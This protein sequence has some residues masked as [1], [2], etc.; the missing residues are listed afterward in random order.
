MK[1]HFLKYKYQ[2]IDL[3]SIK[4]IV[5]LKFF[6]VGVPVHLNLRVYCRSSLVLNLFEENFAHIYWWLWSHMDMR[7][8]V[9]LPLMDQY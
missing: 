3:Y 8:H 4:I 7:R 5:N 1:W 9:F 2:Q 6:E